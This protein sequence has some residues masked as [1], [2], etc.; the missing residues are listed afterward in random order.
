MTEFMTVLVASSVSFFL[1]GLLSTSA[2]LF[3]IR[4]L[5]KIKDSAMET[6]KSTTKKE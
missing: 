5:L 3:G 4:W 6:D 1:F 2:G